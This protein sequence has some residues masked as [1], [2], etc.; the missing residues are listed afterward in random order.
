[1]DNRDDSR[2][3]PIRFP[4]TEADGNPRSEDEGASV[5]AVAGSVSDRAVD[6][7]VDE[8]DQPAEEADTNKSVANASRTLADARKQVE[9]LTQEKA[10]LYDQLLRRQAEF[11]NFRKRA[12]RDR[13]EVY[14]RARA[15]FLL[16]LL[17]IVDNFDR[18]LASAQTGGGAESL[19]KGVELIH[20]Q[21][22]DALA[23]LGLQEIETVG[24]SF[25]PHLHEAVTM[26]PTDEHTENTVIEEFQR[27]YKLGDRL[28]RPA[29]VKVAASP[30]R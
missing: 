27:G 24:Q 18:A 16:D 7:G 15:D 23:K 10:A 8:P 5:T 3:I 6:E 13:T 1:M 2:D 19:Q 30:E 26:E 11:D 22:K 17:P 21:L 28:L 20:K 9:T 14:N 25:D 29:K 12:D 4:G